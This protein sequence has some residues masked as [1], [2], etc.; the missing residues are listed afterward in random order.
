I[1]FRL[2]LEKERGSFAI[3]KEVLEQQIVKV[4]RYA[5]VILDYIDPSQKLTHVALAASLAGDGFTII[6]TQAEHNASPGS[7]QISGWGQNQDIPVQLQPAHRPRAALNHDAEK[8]AE[9]LV[10]LLRR[11]RR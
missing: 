7:F 4:L 6:R 8:L 1:L 11:S 10:T 5:A 3:I 9:D 2:A